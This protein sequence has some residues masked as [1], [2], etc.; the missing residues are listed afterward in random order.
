MMGQKGRTP[1]EH[2]LEMKRKKKKKEGGE[3]GNDGREGYPF[4]GRKEWR[5]REEEKSVE[6]E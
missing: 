6:R 2:G 1:Q 4:P 3:A 5:K